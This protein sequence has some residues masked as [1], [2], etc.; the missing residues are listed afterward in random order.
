MI[1]FPAERDMIDCR[2]HSQDQKRKAALRS[3]NLAS[4]E[5]QPAPTIELEQ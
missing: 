3:H 5:Q 2:L 4:L 1:I